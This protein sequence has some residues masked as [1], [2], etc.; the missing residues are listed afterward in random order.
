VP[1]GGRQAGTYP[2]RRITGRQGGLFTIMIIKHSALRRRWSELDQ[3]KVDDLVNNPQATALPA[4]RCR[5][6][7]VLSAGAPAPRQ[8]QIA[9]SGRCRDARRRGFSRAVTRWVVPLRLCGTCRL[10]RCRCLPCLL[11]NQTAL[12][13]PANPPSKPGLH[14]SRLPWLSW[15]SHGEPSWPLRCSV[16]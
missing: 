7:A 2:S 15:K 12:T 1:A 10:T 14:H 4:T 3:L 6:F 13:P 5:L 16:C 11:T 9:R 8:A